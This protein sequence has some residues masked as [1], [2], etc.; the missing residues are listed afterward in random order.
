[1]YKTRKKILA[2]TLIT[3]LSFGNF[4]YVI[5]SV[6]Q[7]AAQEQPSQPESPESPDQPESPE[8]PDQPEN[9][10]NPESPDQPESPESPENP[11]QPLQ[12]GQTPTPTPTFENT[13]SNDETATPTPTPSPQAIE[14]SGSEN[15]SD[16][17]GDTEIITGDA[18]LL[19]DVENNLNTNVAGSSFQNDTQGAIISDNN[20]GSASQIDSDSSVLTTTDQTNSATVKNDANLSAQ[21]GDNT[22]R[23]NMNG[24]ILIETGDA[25]TALTVVNQ[26]NTNVDGVEVV[27]FNV[28]DDHMGDIIL[29]FSGPCSTDGCVTGNPLYVANTGNNSNSQNTIDITNATEDNSFQSNVADIE[30]NIVL[31]SDTGYNLASDNM[32]GDVLV[33]TGDASVSASVANFA[34]NN[35]SGNV[36]YGVV[37]LFGDLEGD[38]ILPQMANTLNGS[39]SNNFANYDSSVANTYVQ[40]NS[41]NI[42]NNLTATAETGDNNVRDNITGDNS[43]ETGEASV[44]ASVMNVVNNNIIGGDWWVVFV[45]EA[46]NWIGKIIGGEDDANYA[47]SAGTEFGINPDGSINISNTGNN[48]GSMNNASVTDVVN[49]ST[50][51]QNTADITNNLDLTANTGHNIVKDN[52]QGDASIQTG[53]AQIIASVTNFINNNFVG[54][55]VYFTVVN[56]FGNWMGDFVGLGM[57]KGEDG[58]DEI[59]EIGI[60]GVGDGSAVNNPTSS[61]GSNTNNDSSSNS[62]SDSSGEDDNADDFQGHIDPLTYAVSDVFVASQ[63]TYNENVEESDVLG[64]E[65]DGDSDVAGAKRKVR[66]NMAWL[67]IFIPAVVVPVAGRRLIKK[68]KANV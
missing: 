6:N 57:E 65:D 25:N 7:V 30:N 18:N 63:R 66:L 60:G 27:E 46:G 40:E 34:N 39:G 21:T 31:G 43:I 56:V 17:M 1:M 44:T 52:A 36:Y 26:V 41:A 29:D 5:P 10:E 12:P 45:N 19:G 61:T 58:A 15:A 51:Q 53:D 20:S 11:D 9:P 42:S 28:V 3:F 22:V 38:I 32:K 4:F 35:F 47:G 8:S 49:N 64:I 16:N 2:I 24:D 62:S 68:G 23:N 50:T 37:N 48:M 55:D 59:V 14:D 33:D 67:L 54:G 13:G